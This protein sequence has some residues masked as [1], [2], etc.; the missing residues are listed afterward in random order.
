MK[1][2]E[3]M[4]YWIAI[5]CGVGTAIG[6][7]THNIAVGLAVGIGF[8][9]AMGARSKKK[10]ESDKDNDWILEFL[11]RKYLQQLTNN[12]NQEGKLSKRLSFLFYT[13]LN[14]KIAGS[15]IERRKILYFCLN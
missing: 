1:N 9:V 13:M 8:G 6:V 14:E 10:K 7:A 3:S 12:D 15:S 2:N 11:F 4:G 5:G